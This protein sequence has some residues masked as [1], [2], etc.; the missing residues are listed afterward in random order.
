MLHPHAAQFLQD[1]DAS[2]I[3]PELHLGFEI[4]YEPPR[5]AAS[6]PDSDYRTTQ[7]IQAPSDRRRLEHS[8][9]TF[10]KQYCIYGAGLSLLD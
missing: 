1:P 2:L 4:K 5:C 8:E 9:F 7:S 3:P 6:F 10:K